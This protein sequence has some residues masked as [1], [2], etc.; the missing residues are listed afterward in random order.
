MARP[1]NLK[2]LLFILLFFSIMPAQNL[3]FFRERIEL[4]VNGATCTVN[5]FYYFKNESGKAVKHTLYYPFVVNDSLP[6]PDSISVSNYF[7]QKSIGFQKTKEAIR[8][9]VSVPAKSIMAYKVTYRQQTPARKM[10]Y[11]LTTTKFWGKPFQIAEYLIILPDSLTLTFS[12]LKN[13]KKLVVN[14]KVQHYI[15]LENYLPGKNFIIKW[16]VSKVQ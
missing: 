14:G 6:Y 12:S 8:F 3:Q 11:I 9:S 2:I 10:E 7:N 5:G 13:L 16:V 1:K 4:N 15:R